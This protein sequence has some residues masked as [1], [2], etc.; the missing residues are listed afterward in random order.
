MQN[1][2]YRST[3]LWSMAIDLEDTTLNMSK[4]R[5]NTT[6]TTTTAT[7]TTTTTTTTTTNHTDNNDNND[8]NNHMIMIIIRPGGHSFES[9]NYTRTSHVFTRLHETTSEPARGNS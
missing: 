2:I 3:K 6:T 9:V 5:N 4:H 1:R 7:A 8:N